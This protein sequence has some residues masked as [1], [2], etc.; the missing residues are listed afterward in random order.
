[1]DTLHLVSYAIALVAWF[2][3]NRWQKDRRLRVVGSFVI[4]IGM[5]LVLPWAIQRPG[6]N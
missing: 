5:A 1:M 2:V 4:M 3:W 6:L